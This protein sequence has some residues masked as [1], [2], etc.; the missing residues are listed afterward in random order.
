VS[1]TSMTSCEQRH[2]SSVANE[3]NKGMNEGKKGVCNAPRRPRQSWAVSSAEKLPAAPVSSAGKMKASLACR[4]L[5]NPQSSSPT[6]Q[7]CCA[8]TGT[9]AP[10]IPSSYQTF[11]TTPLTLPVSS[12]CQLHPHHP[13]PPDGSSHPPPCTIVTATGQQNSDSSS[14]RGD[15]LDF[16]SRNS[17]IH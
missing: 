15:F 14:S 10:P 9:K 11:R 7:P 1:S 13:L 2:Q 17:P 8:S 12:C 5:L 6:S 3:G 16:E 4:P